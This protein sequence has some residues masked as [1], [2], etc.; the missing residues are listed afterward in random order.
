VNSE[1]GHKTIKK[2][3]E[4]IEVIPASSPRISKIPYNLL[5]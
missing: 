5:A 2:I 3:E 4:M 1:S